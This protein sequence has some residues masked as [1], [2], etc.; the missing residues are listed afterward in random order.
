MYSLISGD[1]EVHKAQGLKLKLKYK[2]YV[3]V[4][5]NIKVLR[6]KMKRILS[7]KH[8]IGTYLLNKFSLS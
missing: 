3:D 5:F 2:E 8:N 4:L 6:N 1:W 7:E